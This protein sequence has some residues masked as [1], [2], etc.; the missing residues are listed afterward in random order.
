MSIIKSD[1]LSNIPGIV[2]GFSD[3]SLKGN[4]DNIARILDLDK[5]NLLKQV[6]GIK[7]V[8]VAEKSPES[9][10]M[11]ADAQITNIRGIGIGIATADCVPILLASEDGNFVAAVHAGWRGT[12]NGIAVNAVRKLKEIY[13]IESK[14]LKAAIGPCIESCCYEV[15]PEV[16]AEFLNR[17]ED[18]SDYLS[19]TENGKYMLDLTVL[20]ERLLLSQGVLEI[21]AIGVC[22]MCS[23]DFYSYRGD[24]KGTGRQ[25]SVIGISAPG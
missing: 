6:H 11:E 12:L 17:F 24:G 1:L 10:R 9:D 21:E 22:T 18:T 14:N 20:N 13:G 3:K 7:V 25:L 8:E 4:A 15:G 23:P 16:G 19:D 2:H 5:I